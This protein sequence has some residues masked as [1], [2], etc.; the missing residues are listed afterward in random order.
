MSKKL[1]ITISLAII[2]SVAT[3]LYLKNSK[4]GEPLFLT[5]TDNLKN[6]YRSINRLNDSISIENNSI[7]YTQKNKVPL[8]QSKY[9]L[10][11]DKVGSIEVYQKPDSNFA[12]AGKTHDLFVLKSDTQFDEVYLYSNDNNDC[13]IRRA[14][15]SQNNKPKMLMGYITIRDCEL[16]K[17]DLNKLRYSRLILPNPFKNVTYIINDRSISLSKDQINK[18]KDLLNKFEATDFKYTGT[19]D[20]G[21]L[22]QFKVG[23]YINNNLKGYFL[24]DGKKLITGRPS[25]DQHLLTVWMEGNQQIIEGEF[26]QWR[27]LKNLEAEILK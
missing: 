8:S 23:D 18:L 9:D 2:S 15:K 1:I 19:P 21:V 20:L 17:D 16:L 6:I 26:L 24:I 14:T 3:F 5:S 10:W 25:K 12:L 4:S 27:K 7:T 13:Y 22:K 11:I